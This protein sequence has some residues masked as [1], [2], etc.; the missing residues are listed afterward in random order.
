MP[1]YNHCGDRPPLPADEVGRLAALD[2][3]DILDTAPEQVY[4]EF[5]LAQANLRANIAA[6]RGNTFAYTG[7]G[8]SPLPTFLAFFNGQAAANA[9]NAAAYSGANWTNANNLSYL[10]MQNPNP[11]GF[12]SAAATG[13]MGSATLRDNAARAGIPANYFVANPD[14]LGGA[15]ITT[16]TGSSTYDSLQVELRR[17]NSDGLQFQTSYVL[18]HGEISNWETW[19]RE[20]TM[21]RD[22]GTPGDVTHQFKA[23]VVYGSAVRSGP[24][25]GW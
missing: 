11:F 24:Q 6:G 17:R 1:C 22:A 4:D 3:Y 20:Q 9:G 12:A 2:S 15:L 8:T 16:N 7:A 14:L 13:L 18:G 5:K 23:N 19:R 10:A 21:I 25:V